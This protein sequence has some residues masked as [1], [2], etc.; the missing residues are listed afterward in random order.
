MVTTLSTTADKSSTAEY[1]YLSNIFNKYLKRNIE[2]FIKYSL[3]NHS[4]RL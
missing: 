4:L 1:L 3:F 2:I